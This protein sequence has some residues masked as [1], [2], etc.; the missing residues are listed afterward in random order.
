M[1]FF[2]LLMVAVALVP[3]CCDGFVGSASRC[4]TAPR[5]ERTRRLARED[6]G[7]DVGD[8]D[9]GTLSDFGDLRRLELLVKKAVALKKKVALV[10]PSDLAC[11]VAYGAG[12]RNFVVAT[13]GDAARIAPSLA[14]SSRFIS[15]RPPTHRDRF[16]AESL[17]MALA[18]REQSFEPPKRN[19]AKMSSSRAKFFE[20][21]DDDAEKN[22]HKKGPKKK[23]TKEAP[24]LV[25][26]RR[27]SLIDKVSRRE[28]FGGLFVHDET[29]LPEAAD[30]IADLT[31]ERNDPKRRLAILTA[32][33]FSS[34]KKMNA[35]DIDITYLLDVDSVDSRPPLTAEDLLSLD[36]DD[37]DD[38]FADIDDDDD[39][40][41]QLLLTR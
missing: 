11:V 37:D 7:R 12:V 40:D 23:H 20:D 9:V 30:F 8:I 5:C 6:A 32:C 3:L 13:A 28:R 35:L 4:E 16:Q 15:Q 36:D 38:T 17:Y 29:A 19:I 25:D 34:S 10:A 24:L 21:D 2:S 14:G 26:W 31:R 39:D 1:S 18:E 33:D 41:F 22:S 27:K